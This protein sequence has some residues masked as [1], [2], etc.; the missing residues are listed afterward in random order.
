AGLD[1]YTELVK[2]YDPRLPGGGG[3]RLFAMGMAFRFAHAD[4]T[5]SFNQPWDPVYN[6]G[7]SAD[8]RIIPLLS[9]VPVLRLAQ[10]A[11]LTSMAQE[12]PELKGL[13]DWTRGESQAFGKMFQCVDNLG[14]QLVPLSQKAA[15]DL[16]KS[17]MA[18]NQAQDLADAKKP[19]S[20][21]PM[22]QDSTASPGTH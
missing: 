15:C 3:P 11:I 1:S 22:P 17:K 14:G 9:D 20:P 21:R 16:L 8:S 13:F 7:L 6:T 2:H 12:F 18:A 19:Y 5:M 4:W 10:T